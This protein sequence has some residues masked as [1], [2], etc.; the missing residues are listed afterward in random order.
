MQFFLNKLYNQITKKIHS[1]NEIYILS[2][3]QINRANL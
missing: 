2:I 1:N 3:S